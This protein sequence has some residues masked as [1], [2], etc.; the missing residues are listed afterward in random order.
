VAKEEYIR[1]IIVCV[2]IQ[3]KVCKEIALK[4]D[5]KHWYNHVPKS[6]ETS[7]EGKVTVL[8]NQQ[9]R[10]DRTIANNKPDIIIR[11]NEK[12]TCILIDVVML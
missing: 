6:I 5:I 12:G 8:W 10:T 2:E 11:A 1:E 3:F 7:H 9:V 4:L